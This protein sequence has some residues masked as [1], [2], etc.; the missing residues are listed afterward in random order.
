M[1]DYSFVIPCSRT[2]VSGLVIIPDV[3][4]GEVGVTGRQV[5]LADVKMVSRA[6]ALKPDFNSHRFGTGCIEVGSLA[7][8]QAPCRPS[9]FG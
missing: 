7:E 1:S 8:T 2:V 5:G 9:W 4:P 6:Q 3:D